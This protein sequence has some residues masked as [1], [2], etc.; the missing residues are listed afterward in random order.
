MFTTAMSFTAL[1]NIHFLYLLT[2]LVLVSSCEH[3]PNL[4]IAKYKKVELQNKDYTNMFG[5]HQTE[6]I[7]RNIKDKH[8]GSTGQIS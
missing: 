7:I 6:N 1:H 2:I 8:F 4:D 5:L 3:S